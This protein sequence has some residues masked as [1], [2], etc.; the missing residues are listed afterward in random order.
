MQLRAEQLAAHLQKGIGPLYTVWGDE[1]LM[2]QEAGDL[3]RA[4]ARRSGCS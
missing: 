3:V 2:A 1:P 4:A